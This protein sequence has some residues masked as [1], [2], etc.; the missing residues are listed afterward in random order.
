MRLSIAIRYFAGG[1]AYDIS[2]THGCSHREVFKSVTKVVDAVHQCAALEIKFPADHGEQMQIA[3]GFQQK[4]RMDLRIVWVKLM[5]YSCGYR[6]PQTKI[7]QKPV[8]VQKSSFVVGNINSD[9]T[10]R[11][12]VMMM[13][14][15]WM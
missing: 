12:P 13:V 1:S 5:D 10:F 7:V 8:E 14:D 2:L 11:V 9:L 3:N 15:S 4:A 6:N